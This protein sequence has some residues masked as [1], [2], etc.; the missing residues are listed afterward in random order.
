MNLLMLPI[1]L[2]RDLSAMA[3]FN[4]VRIIAIAYFVALIGVQT[5]FYMEK[6]F[7]WDDLVLVKW[8]YNIFSGFAISVFAY[9][10]HSNLF[11]VKI[12]LNNP[13]KRRLNKICL[14][15]VVYECIMYCTISVGGYLSLLKETPKLIIQR[16]NLTKGV[17]DWFMVAG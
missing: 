8:D 15:A 9:T 17:V 5:P 12:E 7:N 13:V 4:F 1:C 16:K 3:S 11:A 14:R 6:F 2:K 10:C